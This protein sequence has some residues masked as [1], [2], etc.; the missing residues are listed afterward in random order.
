M[1]ALS[2][3]DI[4]RA[5]S[6][7]AFSAGRAYERQGCVAPLRIT[8]DGHLIETEVKGT[9]RRPYRVSVELDT[10]R[11]RTVVDG[12]C[13]CPVGFNCKH[14]AAALLA[15]LE[16]GDS[17]FY[18][19]APASE[20]RERTA[21]PSM[22]SAQARARAELARLSALLLSPPLPTDLSAYD[23]RLSSRR[24]P[25]SAPTPE[26]ALP[27]D[28]AAWLQ[29]LE[30]AQRDATE[31]YPPSVRKRLLYV[32]KRSPRTRGPDRIEIELAGIEIR[33]DGSVSDQVKRYD[34]H[35]LLSGQP[36]RF[37][38]PSDRAI[39]RQLSS[40]SGDGS[41]LSSVLRQIIAT[42]RGR[43]AGTNGPV[44][45]EGEPRPG[46]LAWQLDGDG[47]QRL[48]LEADD[49]VLPVLAGEPWYVVPDIGEVGP[50]KLS[51]SPDLLGPLLAAPAVS[52]EAAEQVSAE[53]ARR[54]P[55]IGLPAPRAIA[56]PED[57]RGTPTPCLELF[58]AEMEWHGHGF[59]PAGRFDA[60][61]VPDGPIP[62]AR[63]SFRYREVE[64]P[65]FQRAPSVTVQQAGRLFRVTRDAVAE[66]EAEAALGEIGFE[67]LCVLS[68]TLVPEPY[69]DSLVDEIRQMSPPEMAEIQAK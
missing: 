50:L 39:L 32:T 11:G 21:Q 35:Q 18:R 57:V 47:T 4:R 36:P 2:E 23:A 7:N 37:L 67:R 61:T 66:A 49:D 58:G 51:L 28:V 55:D 38:R 6:A 25:P 42:G 62:L 52:P 16:L 48:T 63:L 29:L 45:R 26:L 13:S 53:L 15:A 69:C 56:P 12:F 41:Q 54:L 33:R 68:F 27:P 34:L 1:A 40:L 17:P 9:A 64:L 46:R 22:G 5:V 19:H 20:M 44:L 14:V 31:D 8:M 30:R 10:K 60:G 65:A 3:D 43:W 24:V 59:R